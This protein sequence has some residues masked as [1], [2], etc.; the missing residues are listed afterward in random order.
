VTRGGGKKQRFC[1]QVHSHVWIKRGNIKWGNLT[2]EF[3]AS[4]NRE[5][6]RWVDAIQAIT[7]RRRSL[8][9]ADVSAVTF[10]HPVSSPMKRLDESQ[11][12]SATPSVGLSRHVSVDNLSRAA[13]TATTVDDNSVYDDYF[14][15][16][17]I[18]TA[19]VS[20]QQQ[21]REIPLRPLEVDIRPTSGGGDYSEPSTAGSPPHT[22]DVV[23][24]QLKMQHMLRISQEEECS[25]QLRSMVKSVTTAV[26]RA[27]A[28][29]ARHPATLS[30]VV[31]SMSQD[32]MVSM[33]STAGSQGSGGVVKSS[34]LRRRSLGHILSEEQIDHSYKNWLTSTFTRERYG[35]DDEEGADS[36]ERRDAAQ[37]FVGASLVT[38]NLLSS[39]LKTDIGDFNSWSWSVLDL[40]AQNGELECFLVQVFSNM[41]CFEVFGLQPQ[42]FL[43]FLQVLGDNYQDIT[44]HGLLHA[45]DVTQ[46]LYVMLKLIRARSIFRL[47][48]LEVFSLLVAA[49]CHDLGHPGLV[50][51]ER[52]CV[53]MCACLRMRVCECECECECE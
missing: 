1:F 53:Y 12:L 51:L 19:P 25:P 21:Q 29:S 42:V 11:P 5:A 52:V 48:D 16:V 24:L 46:S 49:L 37:R 23:A 40:D 31:R 50:R 26:T 32:S 22:L 2:V 14:D 28:P 38:L 35:D 6:L 27:V 4:S 20:T 39:H 13:T 15:S 36:I 18:V 45:C 9:D 41:E 43:K 17:D 10:R 7:D 44:F 3:A 33:A 30:S 8:S 34:Q 47:T